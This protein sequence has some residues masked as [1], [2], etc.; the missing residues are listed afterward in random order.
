MDGDLATEEQGGKPAIYFT[1]ND[2]GMSDR[3]KKWGN[4]VQRYNQFIESLT[5]ANEIVITTKQG[6]IRLPRVDDRRRP[7]ADAAV[8]DSIPS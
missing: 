3:K 2:F 7:P 8:S 4:L 5:A 1:Q 6:V